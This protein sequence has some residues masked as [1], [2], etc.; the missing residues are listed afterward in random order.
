[1]GP[2]CMF[3]PK[4]LLKHLQI[5]L[6]WF[7]LKYSNNIYENKQWSGWVWSNGPFIMNTPIYLEIQIKHEK[8]ASTICVGLNSDD[9]KTL[10]KSMGRI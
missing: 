5:H 1:M 9:Y 10:V 3:G 7:F 8:Q 4:N 2:H 6:V